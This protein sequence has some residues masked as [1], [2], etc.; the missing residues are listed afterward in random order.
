LVSF[1]VG[2]VFNEVVSDDELK[3]VRSMS[4]TEDVVVATI[5]GL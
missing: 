1:F 2:E 4:A 3:A 5:S